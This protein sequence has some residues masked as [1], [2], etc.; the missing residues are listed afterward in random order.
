MKEKILEA[1]KELGFITEE[2]EGLGYSF[3]YEGLNYLYLPV[4]EDEEFLNI[5]IPGFCDVDENNPEATNALVNKIN[6]TLKYVKTYVFGDS[7]WLF[8]ERELIGDED[9]KQVL[10]HMI[11]RL[12]SSLF[13]ARKAMAEES[14]DGGDAEEITDTDETAEDYNDTDENTEE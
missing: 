11:V 5:S 13:F 1:M 14:K 8:Y 10:S 6:S 3:S 9:L 2:A 4:D 7:L 12:D